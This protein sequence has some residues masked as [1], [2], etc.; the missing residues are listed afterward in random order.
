MPIARHT[1]VYVEAVNASSIPMDD[2]IGL[3][4]DRID[5][6]SHRMIGEVVNSQ[7]RHMVLARQWLHPVV[8]RGEVV[9][10][11]RKI[12]PVFAAAIVRAQHDELIRQ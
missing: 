5:V 8:L 2:G 6:A 12:E 10:H 3:A 9:E 11:A 4:R 7:P 1:T